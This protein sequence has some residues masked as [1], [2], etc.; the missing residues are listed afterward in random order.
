M[1]RVEGVEGVVSIGHWTSGYRVMSFLRVREMWV[2]VLERKVARC[3]LSCAGDGGRIEVKKGR[4]MVFQV[5]LFLSNR[6]QGSW[7]RSMSVVLC[8]RWRS[9]C[10]TCVDFAVLCG[11]II[12]IIVHYMLASSRLWHSMVQ[13]L[14]VQPIFSFSSPQFLSMDSCEVLL[15]L[16]VFCPL[17]TGTM[18]YQF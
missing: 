9:V 12:I 17:S 11:N 13:V 6:T 10:I 3:S 16:L 8:A 4:E 18:L 14:G 7:I 15:C 2:A 5:W 1:R